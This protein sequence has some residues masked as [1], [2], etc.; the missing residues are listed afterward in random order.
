MFSQWRVVRSLPGAYSR[1]DELEDQWESAAVLD[2]PAPVATIAGTEAG[3]DIDDFDWWHHCYVETDEPVCIEF[4]GLTFPASVFVDGSLVAECESMFL[5]VRCELESGR[6]EICVYF[7]SLNAWLRTRRPRG[8]WRSSLVSAAGMRWARTTLLGRAPIYGNL[9]APVGFWRPIVATPRALTADFRIIADPV[10]GAVEIN[11]VMRTLAEVRVDISVHDPAGVEIAAGSCLT[12]GGAFNFTVRVSDPQLWWPHGYGPQDLYGVTIR[13]GEH[14]I[15]D[16]RIG[17]RSVSEVSDDGGFGLR[18]NGV[19][20]FCRGVTWSPPDPVRLGVDAATMRAHLE[21]F[22]EAGAN[23]VRVVGG[24]V[25][26]QTEFWEQ[27][28]ELGLMVWQ[29]AMQATFDPSTEVS[30]L[31][32]REIAELL[33][34]VSGNPALTVVSGGSETLQRPEMLGIEQGEFAMPVIDAL[35]P[36]TVAARS[37]VPY[38]R[39][40]PA[41][42]AGARD[43]AIRPDTGNAHWFGVGGYMRSVSDV[44]S[45]GVRFAAECLAFA[46]P[47][48]PAAVEKYFGSA[49]VAGHHPDWKAEI[50]RDRGASWDFEDVRDFYVRDV[51]GEDPLAVRRVDPERYLELGRLAI[52]EAMLRC[53]AF[54]RNAKSGCSGAIVLAGKD[55]RPGAGW[56]L[57]DVDGDAKVAMKALRRV[58]APVSVILTD[59]GHSGIRID[60]HN[61]TPETLAGELMLAGTNFLGQGAVEAKRGVT[62]PARSSVTYFDS[63]ISGIF[64]DL[65]HAFKFG[66]PTADAIEAVVQFDGIP[67]T[68]RDA[69]IVNPRPAQANSGICATASPSDDSNWELEISSKVAL[70]YV[71]IDSPGWTPSDNYFHLPA[72]LPYRVRLQRADHEVAVPRG[73]VASIDCFETATITASL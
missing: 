1:P 21:A 58:W 44:R 43:F 69:L 65:S 24:L 53:F 8:R 32:V 59:A 7:R 18:I 5:P 14:V 35:L 41:P 72:A 17:F 26:E 38:V 2:V 33:D 39:A 40:S 66:Q 47:P 23:I 28:A 31:I 42:P 55:L 50:P 57:M 56:G 51:F 54:W 67:W 34:S 22:A 27:C 60:L 19:P 62:V 37:D 64:R 25:Y 45:A 6:H 3:E 71:S 61:D 20:V 11:G 70:R 48:S 4:Q 29:D 16:R 13:V 52:A 9:P 30:E 73:K 12:S 15:G 49:A 36:Q 63:D 10:T 68:I 46:N